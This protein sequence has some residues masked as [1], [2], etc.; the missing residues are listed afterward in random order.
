M[1]WASGMIH[2]FTCVCSTLQPCSIQSIQVGLWNGWQQYDSPFWSVTKIQS[3]STFWS[4]PNANPLCVFPQSSSSCWRNSFPKLGSPKSNNASLSEVNFIH[5]HTPWSW[6]FYKWHTCCDTEWKMGWLWHC[7]RCIRWAPCELH[8]EYVADSSLKSCTESMSYQSSSMRYGSVSSI[9]LWP[10]HQSF[11]M[12]ISHMSLTLLVDQYAS[13][14][15]VIRRCAEMSA[16][17]LL[18]EPI[19]RIDSDIW[20]TWC[21]IRY[22]K[23]IM[24]CSMV[25]WNSWILIVFYWSYSMIKQMA[26]SFWHCFRSLKLMMWIILSGWPVKTSCQVMASV[27]AMDRPI[28]N[29]PLWSVII[30]ATPPSTT[31]AVVCIRGNF[32]MTMFLGLVALVMTL[33]NSYHP[34]CWN[35]L[36]K[37]LILSV[38][39]R[40][41]L[42]SSLL[43]AFG[44]STSDR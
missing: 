38:V 40:W 21:V 17:K 23:C 5:W 18:V 25:F 11:C 39:T 41:I 24:H 27:S 29:C 30:F 37:H 36:S 1:I 12:S 35:N 15:L 22:L 28:W 19:L 43:I 13:S 42:H 3:M 34:S 16:V 4:Y 8:S 9:S 31:T 26:R 20:L 44:W 2:W 6:G 33:C 14:G 10:I 7:W 32:W